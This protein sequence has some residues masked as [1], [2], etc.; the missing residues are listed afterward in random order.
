MHVDLFARQGD[1]RWILTSAGKLEDVIELSSCNCRLK[2]ADLYEKI[3]FVQTARVAP[4][5]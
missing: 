3:E 2:M 4:L 5:R 1:G